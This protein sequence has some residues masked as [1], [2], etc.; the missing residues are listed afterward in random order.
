LI[1]FIDEEDGLNEEENVKFLEKPEKKMS[2]SKRQKQLKHD[3]KLKIHPRQIPLAVLYAFY[4]SIKRI[5][6]LVKIDEEIGKLI[7]DFSKIMFIGKGTYK[8]IRYPRYFDHT[9]KLEPYSFTKAFVTEI[10]ENLGTGINTHEIGGQNTALVKSRLNINM[11][12][13]KNL[14]QNYTLWNT[15]VILTESRV[16]CIFQEEKSGKLDSWSLLYSDIINVKVGITLVN[17]LVE[18]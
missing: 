8:R 17:N 3:S 2:Q 11:P 10:M 1:N 7:I 16:I 13:F 14:F 6:N 18:S 9:K 5:N 12:T 15:E 4:Q